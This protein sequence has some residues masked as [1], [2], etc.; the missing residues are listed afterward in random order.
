MLDRITNYRCY[1]MS[2]ALF[3]NLEEAELESTFWTNLTA[4]R[5]VIMRAVQVRSLGG[6]EVLQVVDLPDPHPGLGEVLVEVAAAGV[7]FIDAH[8]RTGYYP[9]P[10]PFVP[11]IEGAGRVIG[12]GEGADELAMGQ[13][14]AWTDVPGSYA[15]RIAVPTARAVPVPDDLSDDEAAASLGQGLTALVL[16]DE[17]RP[18]RPGDTVLV[19]AAAGGTGLMITQ[20]AAAR[21][22]R[23]I[24]TVSTAVKEGLARES[25][26]AEVIR[27]TEVDDLAGAVRRL[28]AG[29]GVDAVFDGVGATTFDATLAGL[30]RRGTAVLYGETSG[31]V[32][33]VDPER[34]RGG[35][36]LTL[37][38]PSVFDYVGTTDELRE[39]ARVL[40][41]AIADGSVRVRI[42]SRRSLDDAGLAHTDLQAR[43]TVG[44]SLLVPASA[45]G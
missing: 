13:R 39:R 4:D 17:V 44:K 5:V 38:Y 36:S 6:P 43:R 18:V 35:G 22:A 33:P 20:L 37:V 7:N 21:G 25:G 15:E 45:A 19:H 27:Y 23:V 10:L 3:S 40:H 9:M 24:A 11:G 2:I 30:R 12:V 34:L 26:A 31:P 42:N 8:H 1:L 32:A 16:V 28:T 29:V 41:Q 14:I